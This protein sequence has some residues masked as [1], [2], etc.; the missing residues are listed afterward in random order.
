MLTHRAHACV[1][2]CTGGLKLIRSVSSFPAAQTSLPMLFNYP[3]KSRLYARS[4]SRSRISFSRTE[5]STVLHEKGRALN[6]RVG[7]AQRAGSTSNFG[8]C[9]SETSPKVAWRESSTMAAENAGD[10]EVEDRKSRVIIIAG[11]TGVGKTRLAL[12]LAKRLGGEIISADSVQVC[13]KFVFLFFYLRLTLPHHTLSL[14]KSVTSIW[15]Q[16]LQFS[17]DGVAFSFLFQSRVQTAL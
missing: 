5:L 14:Q 3:G 11:P 15:C 12:A 1:C 6:L 9:I 7:R 2:T 8:V 16:S 13:V 10:G 17:C 4:F